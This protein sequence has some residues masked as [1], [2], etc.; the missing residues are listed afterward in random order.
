M[1]RPPDPTVVRIGSIYL[2]YALYAAQPPT[3]NIRIYVPLSL[4]RSLAWACRWGSPQE[5]NPLN[6]EKNPQRFKG[7]SAQVAVKGGGLSSRI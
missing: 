7:D 5:F 3:H 1:G 2:L 6:L 4:L